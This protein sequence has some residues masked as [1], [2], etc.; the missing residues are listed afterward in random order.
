MVLKIK[1]TNCLFVNFEKKK[2]TNGIGN[3]FFLIIKIKK[4]DTFIYTDR[5]T[6]RQ[7]LRRLINDYLCKIKMHR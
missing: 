2:K 1:Q 5:L 3:I 7:T 4:T 6:D